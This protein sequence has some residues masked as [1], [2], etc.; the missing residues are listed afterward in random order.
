M[1]ELVGVIAAIIVAFT[2]LTAVASAD[3]QLPANFVDETIVAGGTVGQPG[4]LV[5]PTAVAWAPDGS[6]YIAEKIGRVRR[7]P[8]GGFL[9]VTP[10]LDITSKVSGFEDRGLLGI[11][12]D[13]DFANH[14]FIYA[15]YVVKIAGAPDG[16]P[17]VSRL[18][19]FAVNAN[20]S[21][22]AASET[23]L[24]GS[25]APV[26]GCPAPANTVDCIADDSTT[27]AIGTVRSDSDGTL[28]LGSGDGANYNIVDPNAFRTYDT[29]SCCTSTATA[30]GFRITRSA[31]PTPT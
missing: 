24:V 1:R 12:I 18:S 2:T 31:R 10:A 4:E 15:A 20:G 28:W 7:V 27:H 13:A 25:L 9:A 23:V 26:G 3:I 22:N 17:A 19:R 30:T 11:A 29:A 6:L 5:F 21:I 8:P 14:R 16:G